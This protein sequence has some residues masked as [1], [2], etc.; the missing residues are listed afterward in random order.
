MIKE[1][2]KNLHIGNYK[3]NILKGTVIFLCIVLLLCVVK[4]FQMQ[5]CFVLGCV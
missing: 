5:H 4:I 1:K 2:K 3:N